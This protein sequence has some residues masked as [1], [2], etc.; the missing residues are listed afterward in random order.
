M[1]LD[2]LARFFVSCPALMGKT[3]HLDYLTPKIGSVSLISVG[4]SPIL[5]RY[6]DG[7]ALYQTVFKLVLREPF[8]PLYSFAKFYSEFSEWILSLNP[9]KDLPSLDGGFSPVSLDLLRSGQIKNSSSSF[10]EFEVLCRF[11]YY[12]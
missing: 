7:S 3:I 4:E 11:V 5:R 9:S 8:S 6:T 2:V 12:K 1:F 10:S